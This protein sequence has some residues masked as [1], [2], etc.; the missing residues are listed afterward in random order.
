MCIYRVFCAPVHPQCA[1]TPCKRNLSRNPV[2]WNQPENDFQFRYFCRSSTNSLLETL[3]SYNIPSVF[4]P[5][6][7]TDKLQPLD[8]TVIYDHKEMLKE[9]FTNSIPPNFRSL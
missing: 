8:M 2:R 3:K 6:V 4:V 5:V 9:G 1:L 7:C